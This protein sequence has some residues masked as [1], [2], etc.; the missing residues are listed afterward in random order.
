MPGLVGPRF[1]EHTQRLFYGY[2]EQLM[3]DER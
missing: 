1:G 2:W 3:R